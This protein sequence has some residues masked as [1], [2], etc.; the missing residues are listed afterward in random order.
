MQL[1]LTGGMERA[2]REHEEIV[3]RCQA[4]DVA[5]AATL[6]R[7]HIVNA[8]RSLRTFLRKQRGTPPPT[9]RAGRR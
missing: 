3:A 7:H 1:A 2:E 6:L 8:G 9:T 4:G 5:A